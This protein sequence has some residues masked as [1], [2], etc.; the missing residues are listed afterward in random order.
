MGMGDPYR[1]NT[2]ECGTAR[3]YPQGNGLLRRCPVFHVHPA[4]KMD[5]SLTVFW[6]GNMER[7]WKK[8]PVS[9]MDI[10]KKLR[11]IN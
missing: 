2:Q 5:F 9:G 7:A 1:I 10:T 4:I 8:K 6:M 3:F 11:G